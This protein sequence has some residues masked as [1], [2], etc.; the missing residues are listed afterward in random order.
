MFLWKKKVAQEDEKKKAFTV[1]ELIVVVAIIGIV[2][3]F[4]SVVVSNASER[5]RDAV[6]NQSTANI[7]TALEIYNFEHGEYPPLNWTS[8]NT[9]AEWETFEAML[10]IELPVDPVNSGGDAGFHHHAYNVGNRTYSYF[11]QNYGCT[12]QWYMLIYRPEAPSDLASNV[13]TSCDGTEWSFGG[14]VITTGVDGYAG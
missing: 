7:R 8:S 5:A 11:A 4:I 14:A 13:V 3:T 2:S 6:R 10:G 1:L 12:G 9:P